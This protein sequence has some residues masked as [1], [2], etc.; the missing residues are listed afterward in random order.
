MES[1]YEKTF[2]Q[3]QY[4]QAEKQMAAMNMDIQ[5]AHM[6]QQAPPR[7]IFALSELQETKAAKHSGGSVIDLILQ[8][9]KEFYLR[10]APAKVKEEEA[11]ATG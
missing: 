6:Q 7:Q 2:D 9:Q 10:T 3:V 5:N 8:S 4:Q 11:A 1:V